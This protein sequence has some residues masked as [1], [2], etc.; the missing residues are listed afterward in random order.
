MAKRDLY[1]EAS[2]H[3]GYELDSVLKRTSP[4]AETKRVSVEDAMREERLYRAKSN[5]NATRVL[6]ISQDASLLNPTTQSLDGYVDISSLFDEVHILILRSGIPAK[7]PVLRV[8]DNVWLYTASAHSWWNKT[9]A[10]ADLIEQQLQFANGFRADL[11]IARDPFESALLANKLAK[12]YNR[13]SQLHVLEDFTT[14]EFKKLA[15]ENFWRQFI[16]KRTIPQFP[17]VRTLSGNV[18]KYISSKYTIP[19]LAV[20]PKFN[21]YESLIN[22]KPTINL[23]EKY[24]PFVFII[25]YVGKLSHRSTLYRAIDAARFVLKNP[26]VGMVV[27]GDGPAKPEFKK[28]AKQLGIEEQIVFE[29]RVDDVVPYMKSANM[30]IVTDTDD[31]SDE[32][33]LKGAATGIPM[34]MS[35]NE[36]REDLFEH[37]RSAFLC[38]ETDLQSFTDSINTLL[39]DLHA[40]HVF[41]DNAQLMIQER[42]HQNIKEYKE[43]YRLSLEQAIFVETDDSVAENE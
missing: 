1:N 36:H 11:I 28:R 12:K 39:N 13:P 21:D 17:S 38:E 2:H 20:L 35:R 3:A 43:A 7:N 25:L 15:P 30:L 32:V 34:V 16:P 33:V 41:S 8:G 10:G 31:D 42:F 14:R 40:R 29:S 9:A 37:G 4:K 26:R 23:K 18:E 6:F 27:L 24:R 22:I 5:R 19:D